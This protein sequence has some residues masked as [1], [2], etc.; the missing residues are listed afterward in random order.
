M[1]RAGPIP[2]SHP[3]TGI[4]RHLREIMGVDPHWK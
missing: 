4:D 2:T 3:E 1:L